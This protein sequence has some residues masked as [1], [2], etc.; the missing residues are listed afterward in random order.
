MESSWGEEEDLV[1]TG[2]AGPVAKRRPWDS[3]GRLN[4][5]IRG[6]H[7]MNELEFE[8]REGRFRA[9]DQ[10]AKSCNFEIFGRALGPGEAA[11]GAAP[12][13]RFA[14]GPAQPVPTA[15][16]PHINPTDQE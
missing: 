4:E 8:H 10:V 12:H 3:D 11:T 14:T 16:T 7:R 1:G 13:R 9:I 2:C 6:I 15:T 5:W